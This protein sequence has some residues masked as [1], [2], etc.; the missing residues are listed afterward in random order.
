MGKQEKSREYNFAAI[1][2]DMMR[3]HPVTGEST[4][5]RVLAEALGTRPQTVS[6]YCNGETQPNAE[7]LLR[8]AKFF[9][10]SADRLLTGVSAEN[11]EL[12]TEL[13][14]S[15]DAA[16]LLKRNCVID[17]NGDNIIIPIINNLLGDSSFYNF[18]EELHYKAEKIKELQAMS[19]EKREQTHPNVDMMGYCKWDFL[20]F[21]QEYVIEQINKNVGDKG[22][23]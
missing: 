12:H 18:L 23:E 3:A 4:T 13:G 21:V 5:Q 7:M 2:T 8:I 16:N 17:K 9:N 6:L 11:A 10:I 19:P 15:E 22:H 20:T 14:L 1:L